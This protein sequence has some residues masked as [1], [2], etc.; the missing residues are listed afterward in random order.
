MR[1]VLVRFYSFL[2][3]LLLATSAN[4]HI[5]QQ[6][7]VDFS[8]DDAEWLAEIRFD[9]GIALPEM[10]ADKE[11]L[12]P[13]RQWLIDQTPD[14]H[15]L[16]RKE[17]EKYVRECLTFQWVTPKATTPLDFTVSFPEWETSPPSFANPYTDLGFAYFSIQCLGNIPDTSG[18]LQVTLS[19]GDH[20]DYAFGY[21]RMG[22]DRIV[23]AYP[24][25][26]QTLLSL[27]ATPP[28]AQASFISLLDYGFRHVIPE[29]WDHVLFIAALCFLSF[30]WRP[31]L[32][33]S[34]IFTLGHT[35]TLGLAVTNFIPAFPPTLMAWTEIFIAATIVYVA[36]ENLF[37]H[38]LKKHRL[39]TIFLFGLIHGLGFA[40]VLGDKIRAS[41]DLALPLIAANLGVELGQITVIAIILIT[42]TWAKNKPYFHK[43]T[44]TASL[45]IA[46]VGTY[47]MLERLIG[48]F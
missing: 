31:L 28:T 4:G 29:G 36:V 44:K 24:G 37:S 25:K 48:L 21:E 41:A 43:I 14:Q 18:T 30:A 27:N 1:F 46:S 3:G 8:A 42:L 19:E 12:Q 39:L 7:F 34:L 20:P 22:L 9:A 17:A 6:L 11:A 33:Q 26:S 10:R 40:S 15:A 23:T 5:V 47:W 45:A 13:K 38:T 16:L 32:S 2:F 35:I